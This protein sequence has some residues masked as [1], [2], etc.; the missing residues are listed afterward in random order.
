MRFCS[1]RIV[2]GDVEASAGF[3]ARLFHVEATGYPDYM[4]VRAPG[5]VLAFC[6]PAALAAATPELSE[7]EPGTQ[8][9]EF[10]VDDLDD[11]E[12]QLDGSVQLLQRPTV[13]PWG[14]RSMIIRTDEGTLVNF[15]TPV[16]GED[17]AWSF[18]GWTL[19]RM[20]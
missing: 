18:Q 15:F 3:F 11:L 8:I 20:A 14:N 4:E 17:R 10:E 5:T 12:R 2:A 6:T 9:L 1:V 7:C 13:Q 16:P 19:K